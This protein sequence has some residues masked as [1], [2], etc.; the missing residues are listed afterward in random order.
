MSMTVMMMG[1]LKMKTCHMGSLKMMVMMKT[2]H[3]GRGMC[4]LQRCRSPCT[5]RTACLSK[6]SH[7]PRPVH[8]DED[9]DDEDEGEAVEKDNEDDHD[10]H[11]KHNDIIK[12][13][14]NAI[15]VH[16][17]TQVPQIN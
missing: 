16:K 14:K 1:S 11:D 9:N 7:L 2:C 6:G 5:G 13:P 4:S 15:F 3:M 17:E 8:R 12:K 10:E